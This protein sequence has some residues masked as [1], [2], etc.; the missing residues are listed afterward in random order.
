MAA[1]LPSVPCRAPQPE[2]KSKPIP[3]DLA[4]ELDRHMRRDPLFDPKNDASQMSKRLQKWF[5]QAASAA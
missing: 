3:A 4:F 2:Y 1:P 5:A